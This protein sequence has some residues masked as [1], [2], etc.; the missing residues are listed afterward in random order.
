M[1]YYYSAACILHM[2]QEFSFNTDC[3]I[4]NNTFL[5]TREVAALMEQRIVM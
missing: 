5:S 4:T 1:Q 3:S 2:K